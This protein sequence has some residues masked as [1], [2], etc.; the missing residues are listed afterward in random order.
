MNREGYRSVGAI[1]GLLSGIAMMT[2]LTSGGLVIAA[3]FGAGGAVAGG[4]L[5]EQVYDRTHES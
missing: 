5:G 4:M 2:W 3:V 1:A